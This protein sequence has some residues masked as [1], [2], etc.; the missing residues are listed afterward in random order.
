MLVPTA[1]SMAPAAAAAPTLRQHRALHA[2]AAYFAERTPLSVYVLLA[3]GPCASAAGLGLRQLI[4]A[5]GTDLRFDIAL[6][7][8][9]LLLVLLRLMDDVKDYGKDQVC[10]PDRPLPRGLLSIGA[11]ERGVLLLLSVLVA[12]SALLAGIY[13][14]LH[15][16]LALVVAA[17]VCAMYYEFGMG[18]WLAA[19]P[20]LYA[21]THQVRSHGTAAE[22]AI[23]R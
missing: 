3:A 12:L 9:L 14:R 17:Y 23:G 8:T 5:V 18:A 10:H 2:W 7:D 15:G 20:F 19:R 4:H 1:A 21:L 11:A 22:T 16:A 13:G 6:A